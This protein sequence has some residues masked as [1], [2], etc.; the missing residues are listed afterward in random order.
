MPSR[1]AQ[2]YPCPFCSHVSEK[3]K[4]A[5]AHAVEKHAVTIARR[6]LK[7]GVTLPVKVVYKDAF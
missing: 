5:Q 2:S 3:R 1:T 7:A 4:T 6:A